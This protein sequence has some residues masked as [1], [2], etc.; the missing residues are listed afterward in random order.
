MNNSPKK[1]IEKSIYRLE[2]KYYIELNKIDNKINALVYF[3]GKIKMKMDFAFIPEILP[4]LIKI[5]ELRGWKN[6]NFYN[7]VNGRFLTTII[8]L[9]YN[10]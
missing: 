9:E 8:E 6:V 4:T 7:E 3:G 5:Y 2:D 1:I 10:K